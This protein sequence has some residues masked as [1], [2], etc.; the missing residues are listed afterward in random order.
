MS[1]LHPALAIAGIAAIAIP[2]AIHLLFRQR[3]RPIPWAA[4][5]FLLEAYRRKRKRLKVQQWLLL[6][7]RCLI[8][9][10]LGLAL[11]RPLLDA[12]GLITPGGRDVYLLVDNSLA[13]SLRV[14]DGET[15]LE[16]HAAA[17][18]ELLQG[19]GS[20]DRVGLITLGS[21]AAPVVL[22]PSSDAAAVNR[23]IDELTPTDGPADLAGA[24]ETLASE[25][26]AQRDAA[27]D[28]RPAVVALLSDLR[29][30]SADI[31][32]ALPSALAGREDVRV[33]AMPPTTEAVG[34]VQV[35]GVEPLRTVVLTGAGRATE[36]AS[37]RVRL[38]RTGA[39][40]GDAG[41]TTVR[42]AT[43]SQAAGFATAGSRA[44][45]R[46]QPG[47]AETSV[48]LAVALDRSGEASGLGSDRSDTVLIASIDRD[49]LETDNRH[50][51]L[52]RVT[53][54]LDVGIVAT[55]RFGRGPRVG[56]KTP[57]DWLRAALSPTATSPVVLTDVEP[58]GIDEPVLATLDAL[59]I[60]RPDL[61]PE[62]AWPRLRAFTD[63]G[64]LILVTPP[65]GVTVHLWTDDFTRAL[66]LNWTIAREA[67]AAPEDNP[68]TLD[69]DAP[70]SAILAMI[71]DELEP[72]LRPVGLFQTLPITLEGSGSRVLLRRSDGSPWLVAAS[73]GTSE[74]DSGS[75]VDNS[76]PTALPTAP[77]A[78]LVIYMASSPSLDWTDLPA[79]PFMVPLMQEL[80]RQGV[81]A[82]D[83]AGQTVAGRVVGLPRSVRR[84]D[85]LPTDAGDGAS[86]PANVDNVSSDSPIPLREAG[87]FV[88][89]DEAQR[90]VEVLAVN[91]DVRA[92]RT[93]LTDPESVRAWLAG[94]L[95][96]DAAAD[97]VAWL[98]QESPGAVLASGEE[99]SPISLPLLIAAMALL[100]AETAMARWF[101][102]ATVDRHTRGA[103]EPA[104]PAGVAVGVMGGAT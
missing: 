73:P 53:D 72:L 88:A 66:G 22:P 57:A 1:F 7:T 17:A 16:R 5:R 92:G 91:P 39:A 6:A 49:A 96:P 68:A 33:L 64:G 13:S 28:A 38:R 85:R 10:L 34:N 18:R 8:L 79:R 89:R 9:I 83:A 69:P 41:V 23:L 50:R 90:I 21:P 71:R 20:G 76:S 35:T 77:S 36:E 65:V 63:R 101:S 59:F 95:G 46:W 62:D 70:P 47:Q 84:L 81:G 27:E 37:V 86:R 45:V 52:V 31:S 2:I 67:L 93:G 104:Q 75:N 87:V 40:I 55:R 14:A 60:T 24:L 25:L 48:T 61:V 103:A 82:S 19:L 74:I 58:A 97:R 30:G 29:E 15:A 80:L 12:A 26:D 43:G 94:A 44:T 3:R 98:D 11:G 78:G 102:H 100:L 32:R 51:R 42:L 99:G 56:E 4:M 54:A